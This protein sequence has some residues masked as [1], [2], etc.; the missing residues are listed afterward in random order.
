M[1]SPSFQTLRS[2]SIQTD[3]FLTGALVG[4]V[5]AF[6]LTNETVQRAAI[7]G[8]AHAWLSLRSGV[9]EAK[10]RFRDAEAEIRTARAR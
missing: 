9:E 10:E 1:T 4:G 3:Q 5:V 2:G 8:A 6:L 7:T